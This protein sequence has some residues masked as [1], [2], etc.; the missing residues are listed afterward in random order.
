M[1]GTFFFYLVHW[2]FI[3]VLKYLPLRY[4]LAL[5]QMTLWY[6]LTCFDF[7]AQHGYLW[8]PLKHFDL[9]LIY[10]CLYTPGRT[11]CRRA[12]CF[13]AH[14]VT[15]LRFWTGDLIKLFLWCGS[16]TTAWTKAPPRF[17]QSTVA[18]SSL[19]ARMTWM[20]RHSYC[21]DTWNLSRLFC[22][23]GPKASWSAA[24][25][26]LRDWLVFQ[27]A[28]YTWFS[29]NLWNLSKSHDSI[30]NPDSHMSQ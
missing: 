15:L 27:L 29:R 5:H 26:S 21:S 28:C 14:I 13:D 11:Y 18:L 23:R 20:F 22:T 24:L 30:E 4:T 16:E 6:S 17:S 3:F 19:F 8:Y 1:S 2:R 10:L 9:Q 25:D 12:H 7:L